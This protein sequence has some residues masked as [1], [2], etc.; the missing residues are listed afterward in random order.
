MGRACLYFLAQ[1]CAGVVLTTVIVVSLVSGCVARAPWSQ[2]ALAA[3]AIVGLAAALY[4]PWSQDMAD[5]YERQPK[6]AG[7]PIYSNPLTWRIGG[8]VLASVSVLALVIG[9]PRL[10]ACR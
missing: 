10:G 7:G 9:L 8:M 1:G 6:Y 5:A 3:T 4:R 2:V